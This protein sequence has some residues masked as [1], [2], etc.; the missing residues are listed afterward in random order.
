MQQ[1]LTLRLTTLISL[2]AG[3]RKSQIIEDQ[4]PQDAEETADDEKKDEE[5]PVE[6]KGTQT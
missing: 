4:P 5:K 3:N 1:P 6:T 2:V